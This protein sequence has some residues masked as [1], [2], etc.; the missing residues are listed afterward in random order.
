MA[1]QARQSMAAQRARVAQNRMV[2]PAR[3]RLLPMP[4]FGR[5][6]VSVVAGQVVSMPEDAD[7]EVVQG[8]IERGPWH[9]TDL[10]IPDNL[11]LERGNT[12]QLVTKYKGLGRTLMLN[13]LIIIALYFCTSA[14]FFY[15]SS[16]IPRTCNV[17][18][19]ASFIWLGICEAVLG[20]TMI[21]FLGVAH[22][23]LWALYHGEIAQKY[24]LQC[25]E[26]EAESEESDFEEQAASARNCLLCP[27]FVYCVA[28]ISTLML[29]LN[30]VYQ[31]M[32][33]KDELCGH[34]AEE[35]WLLAFITMAT[36]CY[37]SVDSSG[38]STVSL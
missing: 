6:P 36:T 9:E 22:Q 35:F 25:R 7:V 21:C 2:I 16:D 10:E 4:T 13:S 31:A 27:R 1:A 37:A 23:M 33:A 18:F 3:Q 11:R 20:L 12:G 38:R 19:K 32:S 14:G 29:W 17:D 28:T 8:R 15:F 24:R 34:A 5:Q 26:E 30:G